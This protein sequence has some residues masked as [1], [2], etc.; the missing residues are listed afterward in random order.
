[1]EGAQRP[2]GTAA[3]GAPAS[4]PRRAAGE[5][6]RRETVKGNGRAGSLQGPCRASFAFCFAGGLA[7]SRGW[8]DDGGVRRIV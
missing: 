4:R 1:M 6:T 2:E 5:G 8:R 3:A 7:R